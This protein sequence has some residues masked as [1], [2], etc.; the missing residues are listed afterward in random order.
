MFGLSIRFREIAVG[1]LQHFVLIAV[2][3]LAAER[4]V[5]G[6][7]LVVWALRVVFYCA[8]AHSFVWASCCGVSHYILLNLEIDGLIVAPSQ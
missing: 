7:A 1:I 5:L 3:Q 4:A 8:L 2:A 6:T